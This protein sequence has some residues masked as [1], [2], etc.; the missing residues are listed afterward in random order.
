MRSQG[1]SVDEQEVLNLLREWESRH[2]NVDVGP[3]EGRRTERLKV[4]WTLQVVA[5]DRQSP[6]PLRVD[7]G[8]V[9]DISATGLGFI[10]RTPISAGEWC[11]C[12]ISPPGQKPPLM[13]LGRAMWQKPVHDAFGAGMEFL[14]WHEAA[15]QD[16]ALE[17][18]KT[19]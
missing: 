11:L 14:V 4:R 19:G 2:A 13:V 7:K 18:A 17:M 8:V 10:T 5:V 1:G 15:E 3:S 6:K 9:I 16:T 12:F